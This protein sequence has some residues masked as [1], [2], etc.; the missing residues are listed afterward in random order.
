M[1]ELPRLNRPVNLSETVP[2][3]RSYRES[4]APSKDERHG[5][6]HQPARPCL[7]RRTRGV[8]SYLPEQTL[9]SIL[10]N[11][12]REPVIHEQKSLLSAQY[13]HAG[14]YALVYILLRHVACR[15]PDA[16]R[17]CPGPGKSMYGSP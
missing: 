14:D 13:S 4:D 1:Q 17:H 5:L 7:A 9:T 16:G 3:G 8:W 6:L 10:R 15:N 12:V 11:R 2:E